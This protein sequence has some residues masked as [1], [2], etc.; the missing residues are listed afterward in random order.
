MTDRV[1]SKD[2]PPIDGAFEGSVEASTAPRARPPEAGPI[3]AALTCRAV[4]PPKTD[5]CGELVTHIVTF[6]D[7]D[8]A[9]VCQA[10]AIHLEQLAESHGTKVNVERINP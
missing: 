8:R 10:C 5:A 3:P 4:T 7:G 2:P 9:P 6:G 1:E